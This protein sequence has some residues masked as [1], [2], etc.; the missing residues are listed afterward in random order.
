MTAAR[1]MSLSSQGSAVRRPTAR[2]AYG[3][4]RPIPPIWPARGTWCDSS[5]ASS[6]KVPDAATAAHTA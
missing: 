3:P 6:P 2:L 4:A 1:A 5:S